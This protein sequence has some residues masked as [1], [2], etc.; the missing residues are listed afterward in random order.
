MAPMFADL[1]RG[2][3]RLRWRLTVCPFFVQRP[4]DA[5]T[6]RGRWTKILARCAT[7]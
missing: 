6:A 7:T 2:Q 3:W 4:R 1:L 5:G